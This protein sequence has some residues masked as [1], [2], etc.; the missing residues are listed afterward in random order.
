MRALLMDFPKDKNALPVADEYMFGPAFLVCPVTHAAGHE[1]CGLSSGRNELDWTFGPAKLSP[2]EQP[3]CE[4][5]AE[6]PAAVRA[7]RFHRAT[8]AGG[9]IR[10][11]K[12]G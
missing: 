9:A 2:A 8:R 3:H 7:R 4:C 10:D 5:A 1:P 11:G 6:H 12:T